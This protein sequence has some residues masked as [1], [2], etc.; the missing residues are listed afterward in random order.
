MKILNELGFKDI[1][2]LFREG[3]NTGKSIKHIHYHLIPSD[4]IGDLNNKGKPRVML[5]NKEV[6]NLSAKISSLANSLP[7]IITRD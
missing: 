2:I 4:P 3:D 7:P 5:S 6:I 1:N